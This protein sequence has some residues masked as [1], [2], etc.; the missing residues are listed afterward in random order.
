MNQLNV[1]IRQAIPSNNTVTLGKK[2]QMHNSSQGKN[3][4]L[5]A[6]CS[7]WLAGVERD[8]LKSESTPRSWITARAHAHKM[9]Y[10]SRSKKSLN[11]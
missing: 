6:R 2:K 3:L 1:A 5:Y 8:E 11:L 9:Y 10:N 4:Y 7:S